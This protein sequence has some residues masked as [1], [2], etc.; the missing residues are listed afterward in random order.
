MQFRNPG[1]QLD[2]AKYERTLNLI[3]NKTLPKS[4]TS[5]HEIGR[6]FTDNKIMLS[7]GTSQHEEN[8]VFFDGIVETEKFSFC[9]FSSKYCINLIE[10]HIELSRRR[11]MMDATFKICPLGPFRQFLII[12]VAYIEKVINFS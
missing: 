12:Y 10:N 7:I 4:P 3:R 11:F 8:Y 6:A 5:C 9:V 1:V 2:F